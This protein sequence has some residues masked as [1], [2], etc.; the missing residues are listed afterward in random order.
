[1]KK[2]ITLAT[3]AALLLGSTGV[4][5]YGSTF[6]DIDTVPWPGAATFLDQAASLGLMSGYTENGKKYCKPRNP[7]TYCEATQLMYSIMKTYT[8]Q[9]VTTETI[10]KW[11]P[12]MVAYKIPTWAYNAVAYALENGVLITNDLSKFMNG[13]TQNS[14]PREDVGVIFGKALGKIYTVDTSATLTYKDAASISASAA[15]YLDL[16]YD[17]NIMVGDDMG[18]F[19]PKVNIN[20]A[21]MAVLSVKTYNTLTSSGSQ[22]QQ[23]ETPSSGT[24]SC[25]V[26][27]SSLLSNGELFL[28]LKTSSGTGMNVFAASSVK[29]TFEGETV[30]LSDIGKDD[31]LTI[32]YSGDQVKSITITKSAN[33]IGALEAYDKIKKLTSSKIYV[34]KGTKDYDFYLDDDVTVTIDGKSSTLSKLED[35]L[36]D[37]KTYAVKLLLDDDDYV[38]KIVATEESNDPKTGTLTSLDSDELTIKAGSK[39]YTY[40]LADDVDVSGGSS[41][42]FSKLKREYEDGNY[43]I[44]VT[45]NSSNKVTKIT[46]NYYE[47]EENG[48]LTFINS[49]RLTIEA[50]G[51]EYNYNIDEDVDVTINGKSGKLSTITDNYKNVSYRVSL[52]LDRDDYVTEI[53]ATEESESVSEGTLTYVGSSYIKI[54]DKDETEY[55][56]NVLDDTDDIDVE[57]DGKSSSYDKLM[58]LYKDYTYK[59]EL[60]FKDGDVSR[61]EATNQDENKGEMRDLDTKNMT[62]DL[63]ISGK[64]KS[65]ELDDDVTVKINGNSSSLS[66]L[67]REW[68]TDYIAELTLNSKNVVTKI[69]VTSSSIEGYLDNISSKK[70]TVDDEDYYYADDVDDITFTIDG[71]TKDYDTLY[72]RFH[73]DEDRFKVVLTLNGSGEVTKVTATTR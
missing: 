72:D 57:V 44:T 15:P 27:S 29:P 32:T 4:T 36:D 1:M 37:N 25:T 43:N 26:V 47:D 63:R 28:S 60:S 39:K 41:M 5:A 35:N 68:T 52:T 66:K 53:E 51:D 61:I 7:V 45:L 18:N 24:V 21:E 62:I 65:F 50:A 48:V 54:E 14:A 13:T 42:T 33:G 9:D 16:L 64:T 34:S 73:D 12:I 23:P 20:R 22:T 3:T 70:I 11:T 71:K 17:K 58:D 56:Y 40:T 10:T 49:R 31:T 46:V 67:D 69:S 19:N 8:K 6:A 30:S 38:T 55:K 2:M 59:V